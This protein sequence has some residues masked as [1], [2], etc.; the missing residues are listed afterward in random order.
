MGGMDSNMKYVFQLL[1]FCLGFLSII[2]SYSNPYTWFC[3]QILDQNV[4]ST[5]CMVI[6]LSRIRYKNRNESAVLVFLNMMLSFL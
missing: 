1:I 5:K 4:T 6:N 3:C 2:F